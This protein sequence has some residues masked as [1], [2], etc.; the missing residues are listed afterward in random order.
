MEKVTAFVTRGIGES[1]EL[2]VFA[3]P[4]AGI[5]LPAGTVEIMERPETAVVREVEE[6]T[7]LRDV[8][9]ETRLG[10]LYEELPPDKRWVLRP[11]KIF[12][13]PASD[14]DGVGFMLFRGSCI[15][16]LGD[17]DTFAHIAFV[18][19]DHNQQPPQLLTHIEG[20]VRRSLLTR[21]AVRYCYHLTTA[22]ETDDAWHI[23]ADGH[24]FRCF[25]TPLYPKPEIVS[26]QQ[27]W[28][29]AVYERIYECVYEQLGPNLP[30]ST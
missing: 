28:L 15:H 4:T 1:A 6:E 7:G 20:Y 21:R 27:V 10:E 17:H 25:W 8:H 9:L 5:Q 11:T 2:L 24:L 29:D 16:Y 3:H 22:A 19:Y 13:E 23:Q 30:K 26:P 14:A 12:A 18:E